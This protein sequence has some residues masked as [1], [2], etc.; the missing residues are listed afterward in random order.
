MMAFFDQVRLEAIRDPRWHSLIHVPNERKASRQRLQTLARCGVKA[1]FPDVLGLHLEYPL[2]FEMKVE[3]N[4]VTAKQAGWL[5]ALRKGGY[6]VAVCWSAD[7]G[8]AFVRAVFAR[9]WVQPEVNI[10]GL[11]ES[12]RR[13]PIQLRVSLPP[14]A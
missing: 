2:A 14:S 10:P 4:K 1:G 11:G 13:P 3:P 6:S 8:I 5:W 9:T 7:E 12:G